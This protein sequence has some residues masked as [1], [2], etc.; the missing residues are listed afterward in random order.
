V[1]SLLPFLDGLA[2]RKL[3]YQTA[4]SP[5]N[6]S[7]PCKIHRRY[8]ITARKSARRKV[9]VEISGIKPSFLSD[10]PCLEGETN[11]AGDIE[12]VKSFH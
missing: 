12:D 7:I 9:R 5:R 3:G 1:A 10:K 11:Q 4:E 6:S 2:S 8:E